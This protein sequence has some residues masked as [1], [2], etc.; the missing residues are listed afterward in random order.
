LNIIMSLVSICLG[1]MAVYYGLYTEL[2]WQSAVLLFCALV[3]GIVNLYC[4]LEKHK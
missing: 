1:V 3:I 2:W 4:E